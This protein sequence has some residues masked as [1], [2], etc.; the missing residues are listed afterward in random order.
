MTYIIT[1]SSFLSSS[2]PPPPLSNLYFSFFFLLSP[3][4]HSPLFLPFPWLWSSS[5]PFPH[6]QY[7][8]H[9]VLSR[10]F[11]PP[12]SFYSSSLPPLPL[13]HNSPTQI[14]SDRSQWAQNFTNRATHESNQ[15]PWKNSW[16]NV[17]NLRIWS[18]QCI[19]SSYANPVCTGTWFITYLILMLVWLLYSDFLPTRYDSFT[20]DLNH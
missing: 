18:L 13:F 16:E 8:S 1:H 20:F 5:L 14:L 10:H 17:W 4:F 3:Y 2:P 15:K 12:I 19:Y 11:L 6:T 7:S 9:S